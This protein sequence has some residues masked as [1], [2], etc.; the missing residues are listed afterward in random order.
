MEVVEWTARGDDLGAD[1]LFLRRNP[2]DSR[3]EQEEEKE[4]GQE[5]EKEQGQEEERR[6]LRGP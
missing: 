4:Q 3:P 6:R 1:R 5:E 2:E